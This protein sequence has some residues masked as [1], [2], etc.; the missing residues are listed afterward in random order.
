VRPPDPERERL[1]A[2]ALSAPRLAPWFLPRTTPIDPSGR[3]QYRWRFSGA[4]GPGSWLDLLEET[5]SEEAVLALA[6]VAWSLSATDG[7]VVSYFRHDGFLTVEVFELARLKALGDLERAKQD[8][9][10]GHHPVIASEAPSR[11]E[12]LRDALVAGRHEAPIVEICRDDEVL[13]LA[14][15]PAGG[16]A[17]ASVYAWSPHK[18]VVDVY[19]QEWFNDSLD[20][21]Y[22]WITGVIRDPVTGHIVGRGIRIDPFELDES[23][24]QY[25]RSLA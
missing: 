9:H 19:P 6:Y 2:L 7:Y 23:N 5:H 4:K 24:T 8:A 20:L 10:D 17:A 18:G 1:L 12:R 16:R 21:G 11:R 25:R 22:Q 3:R 14:A 13:L 15:G